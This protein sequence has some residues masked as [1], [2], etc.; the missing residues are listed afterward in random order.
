MLPPVNVIDCKEARYIL[1]NSNDTISEILYKSGQWGEVLLSISKF[2][3]DGVEAPLVLDIGANLGAYSIPLA[4]S[5]QSKGGTVYGYEPQK[6]VFYQLCGNVILNRLDNYEAFNLAVGEQNGSVEIP[7]INYQNHHNVGAFSLNKDLREL[8]NVESY[9]D[10]GKLTTTPMISLNSVR[11]PKSPS[12]IKIDVEGYELNV[13]KGAGD[14]LEEHR[15]PPLLFEAWQLDWFSEQR[16]ELLRYCEGLGYEITL[17][18]GDE[19]VA[20]HPANP[21]RVDFHRTEDGII[22]MVKQR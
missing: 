7:A 9:S 16:N 21:V 11:L 13:L 4:K 17:H 5:I 2:L 15:F 6:I 8:L 12:L 1:F 10:Y 20:Q 3:I 14:F 19:Y 22:N 18:L